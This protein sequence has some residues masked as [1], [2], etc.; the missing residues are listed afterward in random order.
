[1][2]SPRHVGGTGVNT[3]RVPNRLLHTILACSEVPADRRSM[4]WFALWDIFI[5]HMCL[6]VFFVALSNNRCAGPRSPNQMPLFSS[7]FS[8]P[9]LHID[10]EIFLISLSTARSHC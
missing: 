5:I 9:L 2:T 4:T 8:F 10:R 1:M 7:P 3:R 6:G